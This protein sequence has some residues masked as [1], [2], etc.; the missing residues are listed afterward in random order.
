MKIPSRKESTKL[1]NSNSGLQN[2]FNCFKEAQIALNQAIF[3][4]NNVR[5]HQHLGFLTPEFFHRAS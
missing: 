5:L 4:Y 2:S 1:L 3:L